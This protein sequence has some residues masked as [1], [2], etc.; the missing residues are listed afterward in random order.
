MTMILS[1][2][3][4]MSPTVQAGTD[5]Y[6]DDVVANNDPVTSEEVLDLLQ[7]Y[8]LDAKPPRKTCWGRVLCLR[9]NQ[10]HGKLAWRRD[11]RIEPQGERVTRRQL[12]S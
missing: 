2:V 3:L 8:G 10:Q 9:V 1:K 6:V 5:S 11:N 4:S 12:F 7:R